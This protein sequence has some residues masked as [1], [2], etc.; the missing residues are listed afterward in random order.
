MVS[1]IFTLLALTAFIGVVIWAWDGRNTSRFA[2]A[3]RL[4]LEEDVAPVHP[5]ARPDGEKA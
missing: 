1:G 5:R 4:P 2:E 3:S